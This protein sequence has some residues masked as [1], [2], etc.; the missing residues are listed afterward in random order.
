VA[1]WRG[2]GCQPPT[3]RGGGSLNCRGDS[4]GIRLGSNHKLI[5]QPLGQ[6]AKTEGATSEVTANSA[7][8]ENQGPG[9]R[10]NPNHGEHDQ[11]LA[12]ALMHGWF[13]EVAVGGDGL[14]QF[15]VDDSTTPARLMDEHRWNG[16]QL[17]VAGIEVRADLGDYFFFRLFSPIIV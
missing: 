12:A 11:R 15:G 4:T 8:K 14:K 2:K 16:A 3:D 17:Q 7:M 5:R 13:L 10:Q 6:I 1:S 9:E